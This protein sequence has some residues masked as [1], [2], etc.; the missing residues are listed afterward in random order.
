MRALLVHNPNSRKRLKTKEI[1]YI[2]KELSV[3]YTTDIFETLGRGSIKEYVSNYAKD[4]DLII[5]SGGDGTIHEAI[6]GILN[7]KKNPTLAIIPR[8]TMNDVAKC[9]KIPKNLKKCVKIIIKGNLIERNAYH[10]NDTYFLYGLAIGRYTSVSYRADKKK[11]LGRLAYYF[12][13][14]K[15][16]FK[17]KATDVNINGINLKISQAFIIDNKYMAG[18]PI[19]A[20]ND[21]SIHLKYILSKNRFIDTFKFLFFLL[22]K[23]KRHSNEIIGKDIKIDGKNICFT[24]D[25][26][27]YITSHAT[28]NKLNNAIKIITGE[29]KKIMI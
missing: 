3:E 7:S 9:Y 1:D 24:L 20:I 11:E 2:K 4:Y 10:I 15:D 13:C 18:Y 27:R 8:G 19:E 28:I 16:F 5:A 23:A 21:D 14:I 17:S 6:I 25:G 12:A 26:E 22:S 29:Q